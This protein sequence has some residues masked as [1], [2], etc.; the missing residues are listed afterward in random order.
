MKGI[1]AAVKTRYN[2]GMVL[3]PYSMDQTA[4]D[5]CLRMPMLH[6]FQDG[7]CS[8]QIIRIGLANTISSV[9]QY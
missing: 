5:S 1:R 7:L 3:V 2:F 6:A 9:L 4:D 8:I